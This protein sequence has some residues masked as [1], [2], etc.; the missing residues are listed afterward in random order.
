ELTAASEK[1][2]GIYKTGEPIRWRIEWKGNEPIT[3]VSYALK[4][5]G[6]TEMGAGSL[7]LKDGAAILEARLTE[8]GTVF[9]E[10]KVEM[11]DGKTQRAYAGAVVEPLKI[12]PSASRPMDF[13]SFWES[14]LKQLAAVPVNEKLESVQTDKPNVDYWKIRMDNIRGT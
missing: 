14:K 2:D 3:K 5:G 6:L 8:P 1:P 7:Q 9:A 10:V 11:E 4:K 13:D 12:G